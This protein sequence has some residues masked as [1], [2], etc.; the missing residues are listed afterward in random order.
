MN[1]EQTN[2][3]SSAAPLGRRRVLGGLAVGTAAL[4]ATGLAQPAF[5]SDPS[6]PGGTPGSAPNVYD[7]TAWRIP[8]RPKV[9][10][11]SDVGAIINDIIADIKKRQTDPD[12]KPGAAIVIPPGDYE[13]HTQV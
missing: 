2:N 8:G 9:T 5:A 11:A 3:A 10:A 12:A 4:A 7:V 13:L 1:T 6:G